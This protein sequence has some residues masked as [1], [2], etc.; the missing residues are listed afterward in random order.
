MFACAWCKKEE[1]SPAVWS[2]FKEPICDECEYKY[3]MAREQGMF[4]GKVSDLSKEQRREISGYLNKLGRFVQVMRSV[5]KV[6]L[7]GKFKIVAVAIGWIFVLLFLLP[8]V[9]FRDWFEN[10]AGILRLVYPITSFFLL[11]Y[12]FNRISWLLKLAQLKK[13]A[14]KLGYST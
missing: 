1:I 14:E 10:E 11:L 7:T 4:V 13:E 8:F 12:L 3:K 5:D 6:R 2:D 9:L